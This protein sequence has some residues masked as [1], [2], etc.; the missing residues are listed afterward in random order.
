MS[1]NGAARSLQ[2]SP[3]MPPVTD[4]HRHTA[5][6][7]MRWAHRSWEQVQDDPVLMRI[8]E[9]RATLIRNREWKAAEPKPAPRTQHN[10]A[11]LDV[12]RIF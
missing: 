10:F 7:E 3:D 1:S 11:G 12:P 4:A 9:L 8:V 6:A 5:F 2:K